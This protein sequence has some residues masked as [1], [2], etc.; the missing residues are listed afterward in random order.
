M[1]LSNNGDNL[2]L[3]RISSRVFLVLLFLSLLILVTYISTISIKK[4]MT[5]PA[6]SVGEYFELYGK[7]SESLRCPCS[8]I[9]INYRLFLEVNYTLHELCDST[10]VTVEWIEYIVAATLTIGHTEDFIVRAPNMFYALRMLCELSKQTISNA[11]LQFY[12]NNYVTVLVMPKSILESEL[13]TSIDDF[14]SFT[15]AN[16]LTLFQLAREMLYA[17]SIQSSMFTN[18]YPVYSTTYRT[19]STYAR[20]YEDCSCLHTYTCKSGMSIFTDPSRLEEWSVPGLYVG[21]YVL[22]ALRRSRLECFYNQTCLD[23]LQMYIHS[24]LSCN[25]TALDA[26]KSIRFTSNTSVAEILDHLM[27]EKWNS[28]VIYENYYAACQPAEC[29]YVTSTRHDLIYIVTTIIGLVGGL[30]TTLKLSI[31]RLVSLIGNRYNRRLFAMQYQGI[32][33]VYV[34]TLHDV[35]HIQK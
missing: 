33:L 8:N 19:V 9:S 30:V 17:N 27:V 23:T 1:S 11:S 16:F 34:R 12:A 15:T 13:N 14:I 22:E 26:T 24:R 6:P 18:Y 2:R 25:A 4:S 5:V 21:C 29:V 35:C 7:Y 31:P 20:E 28:S 3:Q 32:S 10:F